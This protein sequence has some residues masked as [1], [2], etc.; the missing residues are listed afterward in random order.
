MIYVLLAQGFEEI[1]AVYPID[2]LR[3]CGATVK[4]VAVS[5]ECCVTGSNGIPVQADTVLNEVDVSDARAL[6]LP[7]GPGRA[8]IIKNEAAMALV[9]QC[10]DSGIVV[11][12]IC[13]APEILGALGVLVGRKYT[14]YPGLEKGIDGVFADEV[15]VTDGN[16]ITSQ[17][18]GTSEAFAFALAERLCGKDKAD[19]VYKR[20]VSGKWER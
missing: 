7:G 3:R 16:F 14:C 2:V 17:A 9:K 1:E 18:A 5:D 11:A 8:N 20:M 13:G 12:A 19:D 4:T 15:V 10:C 6:I